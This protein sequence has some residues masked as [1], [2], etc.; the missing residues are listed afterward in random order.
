MDTERHQPSHDAAHRPAEARHTELMAA[1]ALSLNRPASFPAQ[2]SRDRD[3]IDNTL[4]TRLHSAFVNRRQLTVYDR[5]LLAMSLH[6]RKEKE[7]AA[8]VLQEV[9]ESVAE[10]KEQATAHV[11]VSSPQYWHA[12]NSE[13]ETNAWLLRTIVALDRNHPVAPQLVN[14]LALNRT[15]GRFWRSTRETALAVTAIAEYLTTLTAD[16]AERHVVFRIDDGP[17]TTVEL[18]RTDVLG[19]ETAFEQPLAPGRHQLT[20]ERQGTE[21]LSIALHCEFVRT[22]TPAV[23][24]GNGIAISRRYFL[25]QPPKA[26][27]DSDAAQ[28]NGCGEPGGPSRRGAAAAGNGRCPCDRRCSGR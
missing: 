22:T 18:T 28:G 26:Q 7:K 12:W 19:V 20:V 11:P 10:N 13:I 14:W 5:L 4:M 24:Q 17:E 21:P 1:Y 8:T 16:D 27:A 23:A 9:L 15:E 25:R 6:K 2:E 3:K